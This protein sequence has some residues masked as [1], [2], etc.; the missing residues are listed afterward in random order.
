MC[1]SH[2]F[3]HSH[4]LQITHKAKV[5]NEHESGPFLAVRE[6]RGRGDREQR[7]RH[8]FSYIGVSA[9]LRSGSTGLCFFPQSFYFWK[10][11]IGKFLNIMYYIY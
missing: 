7:D 6:P 1:G 2:S 11:S 4:L 5:R 9:K 8:I 3:T 10:S